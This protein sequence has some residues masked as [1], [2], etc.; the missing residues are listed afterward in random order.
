MTWEM[1]SCLL[2]RACGCDQQQLLNILQPTMG[3]FPNTEEEFN[4][5]QMILRRTGHILEGAPLN[6]AGQLRT[7]PGSYFT[8]WAEN[9]PGQPASNNFQR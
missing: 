3:R 8:M 1:Y 6:L 7:P 5:M 4:A 2:L 9:N